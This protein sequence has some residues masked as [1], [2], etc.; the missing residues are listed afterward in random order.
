MGGGRAAS[1]HA[2]STLPNAAG[3]DKKGRGVSVGGKEGSGRGCLTISP[4]G[5]CCWCWLYSG[6]MHMLLFVTHATQACALVL[7]ALWQPGGSCLK[8]KK[9]PTCWAVTQAGVRMADA[10][11][12]AVVG[13][14]L[15][16][17]LELVP[18][19]ARLTVESQAPVGFCTQAAGGGR[20]HCRRW[21]RALLLQ[22][23]AISRQNHGCRLCLLS[24]QICW[25]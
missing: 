11:T 23:A 15:S 1:S 7:F 2:P 25:G 19:H 21:L 22:A 9:T 10:H 8:C 4:A 6:T 17:Q 18:W 13:A 16:M 14:R 24:I 12:A 5:L 3:G 20:V